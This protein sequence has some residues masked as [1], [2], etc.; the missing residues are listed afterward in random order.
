MSLLGSPDSFI[1]TD[2]EN[3]WFLYTFLEMHITFIRWELSYTK[4]PKKVYQNQ[5]QHPEEVASNFVN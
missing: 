5:T 1:Y 4:S 2:Y 3:I